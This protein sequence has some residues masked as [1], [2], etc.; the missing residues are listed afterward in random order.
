MEVIN[1]KIIKVN[2]FIL[3]TV[4]F[5]G[6]FFS[7]G[8]ISSA[9]QNLTEVTTENI[10]TTANVSLCASFYKFARKFSLSATGAAYGPYIG[11][12]TVQQAWKLARNSSSSAFI[13]ACSI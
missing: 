13:A 8:N 5:T 9:Q 10:E 1:L 4:I 7:G 6:T 12:F 3:A 11:P 2:T